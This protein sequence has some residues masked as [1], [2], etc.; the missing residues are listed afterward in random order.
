MKVWNSW[1]VVQLNV[2][3]LIMGH[4]VC[5]D[6][7]LTMTMPPDCSA[8]HILMMGAMPIVVPWKYTPLQQENKNS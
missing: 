3:V 5:D 1:I 6:L 8:V 4:R 7:F 2:N